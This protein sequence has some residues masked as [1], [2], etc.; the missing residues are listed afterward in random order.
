M[1]GL[2]DDLIAQYNAPAPPP[3]QSVGSLSAIATDFMNQGLAAGQRTTPHIA[4]HEKNLLSS[5]VFENDA[6]E[7]VFRDAG[8]QIVATDKN[9]HVVLRDPADRKLKVYARSTETNE[10]MLS[11]AGR[12]LMT[13]MGA[14]APSTRPGLVAAPA[15]RAPTVQELKSAASAGYKSPEIRGLEVTPESLGLAIQKL[16]A[17]L[18]AEGVTHITA[19][20]VFGQLDLATTVPKAEPTMTRPPFVSGQNISGLYQ[21]MND[22]I[23]SADKGERTAAAAAKPAIESFM[24]NIPPKDVL[25]GNPAAAAAK[26]REATDNWAAAAR[27]AGLD[28]KTFVAELRAAAANSGTNQGNSIRQ[29]IVDILADERARMGYTRAELDMMERIVRG[30]GPQNALRIL[31]NMM[32]GGLGIGGTATAALGAASTPYGIGGIVPFVG[33]GL[34]RIGMALQGRDLN[35]LSEALRSRSPLGA[36]VRGPVQEWSRAAQ[37]WEK[38]ETPRAYANLN[39]ASRNLANN[40]KDLGISVQPSDLLRSIQGPV[41]GRA[42]DEQQ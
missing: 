24:G 4:S 1:S 30:T 41:R 16:K 6:G 32:G 42:E 39:I 23:V 22:L 29:R 40:L 19:P 35:T 14:G 34:R 37:A 9:K 18:N 21:S 27:A 15:S 3:P 20:R 28:K 2:F 7:V 36:R 26:F 31:G 17:D 5:D 11:A 12:I 38:S 33:Y 8:G 10:G 13:G 25:A